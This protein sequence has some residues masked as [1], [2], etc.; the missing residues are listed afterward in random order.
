[1]RFLTLILL[2]F[3]SYTY[4]QV[5]SNSSL[6]INFGDGSIYDYNVLGLGEKEDY[7]Y[8]QV[9]YDINLFSNKWTLYAQF[10][11]SNPPEIGSNYKGIRKLTAY[12]KSDPIKVEMGD[13]YKSWSKGLV[14]S[15]NNDIDIGYDNGVTGVAITYEKNN[16]F[17]ELI[18]GNKTVLE[19]SNVNTFSRKPDISSNNNILGFM[20]HKNSANINY[21]FSTL[22]NNEKLAKNNFS[23]DSL[24]ASHSISSV[25]SNINYDNFDI[26][27]EYAKKYTSIDPPLIDISLNLSSLSSDTTVRK[28]NQGD[29]FALSSNVIFKSMSLSL[30]YSYYSFHVISP[31]KRISML[32]PESIS[33]FQK[34]MIAYQ[35]LTEPLLNRLTHLQDPNDEIGLNLDISF[36]IGYG[37]NLGYNF[38]SS[39]RTKEWYREKLNGE[40]F[41]GSWK[42][43]KKEYLIP[44][45]DPSSNPYKQ[46]TFY[47]DNFF[48]KGY[49]K[50][51]YSE[52]NENKYIYENDFSEDGKITRYDLLNA[53]TVPI[54][55]DYN[56]YE[57]YVISLG[58]A[59]QKI[60]KGVKTTNYN[61]DPSFI[62][63]FINQYGESEDFQTT[64]SNSLGLAK[65]SKW[66]FSINLEIDKYNEADGNSDNV[67]I[68]P[69]EKLFEPFFDNLD[70]T[71]IS[72]E[73]TY[74]F[75][76]DFRLSIF[77]GSSKGGVSC[78]NGVCRYYPGIS[79]GFRLKLTK[80]FL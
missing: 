27:F 71:W 57:D 17:F 10:E 32:Q 30:D 79:D 76:D 3:H 7:N 33:E 23:N 49:L 15:Q 78:A 70:R 2:L 29:G 14:L 59:V 69:F 60:K 36:G 19:F 75:E 37:S 67:Y 35:E 16:N 77:Y 22:L 9:L 1:M 38:S 39:S 20:F 44:S 26:S 13:I 52:I 73:I 53:K 28:W 40:S 74:L 50:I 65:S 80:S 63:Y 25:F 11:S 34:P 4:T 54:H 48:E 8:S 66:A 62:S 64:Y 68:N 31:S 46:N 24:Y 45:S 58:L 41:Y 18:T 6:K 47:F 5:S 56:I 12:Y 21:G 61:S 42:V 43:L 72:G 51:L 55:L